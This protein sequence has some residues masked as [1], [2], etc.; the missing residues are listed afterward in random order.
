MELNDILLLVAA[1]FPAILT[2][3]LPRKRTIQ[4]GINFFKLSQTFLFQK[5]SKLIPSASV[6]GNF[7]HSITTTLTDLSFGVYVGSKCVSEEEKE[8]LIN[9][10]LLETKE[11]TDKVNEEISS[12]VKKT[13]KKIATRKKTVSSTKKGKVK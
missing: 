3:V 1:F 2:F 9:N 7:I 4:F 10:Y 12:E 8:N 13:V 5:T 6:L 11:D